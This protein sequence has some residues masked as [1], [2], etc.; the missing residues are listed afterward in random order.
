[1]KIV[2]YISLIISP[3]DFVTLNGVRFDGTPDNLIGRGFYLED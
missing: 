1:M 3:V 2:N